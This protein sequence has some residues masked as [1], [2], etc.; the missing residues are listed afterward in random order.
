MICR[1]DRFI[2]GFAM[3]SK[4]KRQPDILLIILDTQRRDRLSIYGHTRATSPGFDASPTAPP[5]SSAPSRRRSGRSRRIHRC[6]PACIPARTASPRRTDSFRRRIPR[7]RR[8]CRSAAITPSPSATIRWSA[9][10]T[11][12]CSAASPSSTTTPAPS[13]TAPAT[14]AKAVCSTASTA[15]FALTPGG[16]ATSSPAPTSCSGSRCIRC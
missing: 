15:G 2:R 9:C 6:S 1:M 3:S 12:V 10:S 11:T 8:F 7:W 16:S 4:P 5:C 13:P 14:P